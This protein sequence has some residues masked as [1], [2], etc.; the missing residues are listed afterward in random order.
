M[1]KFRFFWVDLQLEAVVFLWY[2]LI[3]FF[4]VSFGLPIFVVLLLK[5]KRRSAFWHRLSWTIE[6]QLKPFT[7][8]DNRRPFWIH[9]LSVGE[10][11]SAQPLVESL[12]R[13][14][15]DQP[16]VFSSSTR[17][18]MET[19]NRL[20]SSQV[21]AIFYQSYDFLWSVRRV[22]DNVDPALVVVIETD[23]WP[24]FMLEIKR[25]GIPAL[26]VN[27]RLSKSSF[28]GYRLIASSIAK[29][30]GCFSWIGV[31][32][33]EDANRFIDI[34]MPRER[35]VVTGNI[36][37]DQYTGEDPVAESF[38]LRKRAGFNSKRKILLLGSTHEGE[39]SAIFDA[40]ARLKQKF[41]DLL[42]IVA[43]RDPERA[44]AVEKEARTAG[45][46]AG[47]VTAWTFTKVHHTCDV[48]VIG[49]MGMLSRLYAV[50]DIAFVGG[51][52]VRQGGHN[53]LEP[54][55]YAKPIL[56]GPDMSDFADIACKLKQAGGAICI[57]NST[58][59]YSTLEKLVADDLM[60]NGMGDR[61][62]NVFRSN[63][64]A[65]RKTMEMISYL[66]TER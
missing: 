40:Y 47:I 43:P 62:F 65:V 2:N 63:R 4:V 32:T 52:L 37:F 18:G 31:Q 36:K 17:T 8:V 7:S 27:A 3:M 33:R 42:L 11:I 29:V 59:I 44:A 25:R 48:L 64:G 15:P 19:A 30:L 21:A 10:V 38:L 12:K 53:P 58:M 39:E 9:A 1:F 24:N 6:R 22:I 16:L 49:V 50:A 13:R 28:R 45:L 26:L 46:T 60:R 5:P 20:F 34:G 61:A 57:E 41:K 14:F 23:M 66:H 51:S 56:F 35:V 55:R 54:A